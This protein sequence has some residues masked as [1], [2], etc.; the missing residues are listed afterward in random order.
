MRTE[1]GS[2][3]FQLKE[4]EYEQKQYGLVLSLPM[5]KYMNL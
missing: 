5:Y 2:D 3:I 4:K 1:K